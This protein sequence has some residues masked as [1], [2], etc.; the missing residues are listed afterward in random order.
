M[1]YDLTFIDIYC[2]SFLI[3][4]ELRKA[5]LFKTSEKR[6]LSVEISP[7]ISTNSYVFEGK[8]VIKW[9]FDIRGTYWN[10][11]KTSICCEV[12]SV[13]VV[14]TKLFKYLSVVPFLLYG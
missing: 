1:T 6:I 8:H 9:T 2:K 7:L 12:H 3:F 11:C 14:H 5:I 13:M 10:L 4:S